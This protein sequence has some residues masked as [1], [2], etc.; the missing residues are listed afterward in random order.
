M[1]VC[2]C[3]SGIG[4]KTTQRIELKF[5]HNIR[6]GPGS[7]LGNFF[8]EK[9]IIFTDNRLFAKKKQT[10]KSVFSHCSKR[11]K[12][13]ELKFIHNIHVGMRSLFVKVK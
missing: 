13:F 2:V 6:V 8:F 10:K 7:V 11:T 4:S 9:F 1:C 3:L 5:T 12:P